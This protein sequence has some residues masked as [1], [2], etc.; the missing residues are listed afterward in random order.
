[1]DEPTAGC[2]GIMETGWHIQGTLNAHA[3]YPIIDAKVLHQHIQRAL[4]AFRLIHLDATF[5]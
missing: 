4:Q 1:M 3:N 5:G 2:C